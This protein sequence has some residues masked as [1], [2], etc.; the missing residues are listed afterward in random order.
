M[1]VPGARMQ[2]SFMKDMATFRDPRSK[3]TFLNYLHAHNRLVMFSNL[4]TFYP[5]R[6]E[7]NDYLRWC[8]SHFD[9]HVRYGEEVVSISPCDNLGMVEKWT[10]CSRNVQTGKTTKLAARHVVIAVG[11]SLKI[12][13]Q[14]PR[15]LYNHKILHSSNYTTHTPHLLPKHSAAYRV[16]VVGGGQSAVEIFSDLQ[17]RYRNCR[18]TLFLRQSA[19]RP[20]DDSPL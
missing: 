3:F 6:E 19:L 18:T 2:I 5:L 9:E 7:F 17:R 20:S 11:G 16:A 13:A 15:R 10:V 1:L 4:A 14:F 8:A 12:P